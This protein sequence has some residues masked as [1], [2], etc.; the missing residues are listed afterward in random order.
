MTKEQEK[1][2]DPQDYFSYI[3][4]M[5]EK[6]TDEFLDNLYKIITKN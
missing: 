6:M 4:G 1:Q 3:K 2:M 5:K